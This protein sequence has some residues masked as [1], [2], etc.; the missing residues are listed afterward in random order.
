MPIKGVRSIPGKDNPADYGSK[1][2]KP[3]TDGDMSY[4]K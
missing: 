3:D 2:Y 1:S 4:A